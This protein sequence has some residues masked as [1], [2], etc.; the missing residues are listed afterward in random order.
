MTSVERVKAICKKKRIAI[1]KLEKDLNYSNG[2]IGQ[3]KKGVF[4]DNRLSE[5]AKYLDVSV[6]YLLTGEEQQ[7]K[8]TTV[9]G[10]GLKAEFVELFSRLSPEEQAREI[11]YLRERVASQDN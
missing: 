11:A 2:Y 7:K 5:I 9:L 1:S 8:P 6:Q 3:L 10:N 4:P